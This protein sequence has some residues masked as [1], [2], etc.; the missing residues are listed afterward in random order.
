MES[1]LGNS[2][3][4]TMGTERCT[5]K[6]LMWY[7]INLFIDTSRYN[8]IIHNYVSSLFLD[9]LSALSDLPLSLR[10]FITETLLEENNN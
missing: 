3:K 1:K 5:L 2:V 4:E 6:H 8:P 9:G 10:T 7:E